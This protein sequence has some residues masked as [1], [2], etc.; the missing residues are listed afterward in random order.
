MCCV[1][2][3]GCA[4]W[5]DSLSQPRPAQLIVGVCPSPWACRCGVAGPPCSS[6]FLR[7]RLGAGSVS[8][9]GHSRQICVALTVH[10][11]LPNGVLTKKTPPAT[12][13]ELGMGSG[14]W[15]EVEKQQ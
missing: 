13:R 6:G 10:L 8:G 12:I 9:T 5:V 1:S 15:G 4:A 14:G 7:S 3:P 2:P 11:G